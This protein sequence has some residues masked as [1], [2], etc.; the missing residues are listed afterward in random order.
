MMRAVVVVAILQR[1]E[2]IHRRCCCLRSFGGHFCVSIKRKNKSPRR[3]FTRLSCEKTRETRVR[4]RECARGF[5]VCLLDRTFPDGSRLVSSRSVRLFS[6]L[7]SAGWG[8]SCPLAP[9]RDLLFFRASSIKFYS[10]IVLQSESSLLF[11]ATNR[12]LSTTNR[13]F[14]TYLSRSWRSLRA[15]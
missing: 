15:F 10:L 2:K 1:R 14:L 7:L 8:K 6:L 13:L 12:R 9:P 3:K 11:R 4:S 5:F